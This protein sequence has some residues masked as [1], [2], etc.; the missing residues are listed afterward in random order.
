MQISIP[1]S[2][3]ELHIFS[4]LC[5]DHE[6]S[7]SRAK[8]APKTM[9]VLGI[10]LR[11]TTLTS[12]QHGSRWHRPKPRFS[13]HDPDYDP[14]RSW[15][16]AAPKTKLVLETKRDTVFGP[17][18]HRPGWHKPK[19]G[20]RP[21]TLTTTRQSHSKNGAK[22]FVMETKRD[23]LDFIS[24]DHG[25]RWHRPKPRFATHDR[26]HDPPKV[27][28]KNGGKNKVESWW[29]REFILAWI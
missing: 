4:I 21:L 12:F 7:R 8:I 14:W 11:G 25:S 27:M 19:R 6:P 24:F 17:F 2:L 26:A 9:L 18:Q 10:N 5:L 16:K 22:R 13:T 1:V 20:L 15:P 23:C 3:S 28:D 29:L